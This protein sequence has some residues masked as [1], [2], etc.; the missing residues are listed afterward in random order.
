MNWKQVKQQWPSVQAAVKRTWGR[1]DEDDLTRIHGERDAFT[2]ILAQKVWLRGGGCS[3]ESGRLCRPASVRKQ[4]ADCAYLVFS[5]AKKM[6]GSR[7]CC[8]SPLT[9]ING[10][11]SS[12]ALSM[13]IGNLIIRPSSDWPA[14]LIPRKKRTAAKRSTPMTPEITPSRFA[15]HVH[16]VFI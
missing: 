9:P 14:R 2:G 13:G 5:A 7:P 10:L 4:K 8:K 12:V 1:I 16:C 15:E 6:L 11:S 3:A